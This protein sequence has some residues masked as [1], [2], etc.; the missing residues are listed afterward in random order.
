LADEDARLRQYTDLR[1]YD[2][3]YQAK[4]AAIKARRPDFDES[5]AENQAILQAVCRFEHYLE[6]HDS[7]M[8]KLDIQAQGH[9]KSAEMALLAFSQLNHQVFL[10]LARA[11]P[12]ADTDDLNKLLLPEHLNILRRMK[13]II[14]NTSNRSN[15]YREMAKE[16][17]QAKLS[18]LTPFIIEQAKLALSGSDATPL[19]LALAYTPSQSCCCVT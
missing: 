19:R 16:M 14:K 17:L 6:W 3:V 4:L 10:G 15:I 7:Y 8:E 13:G 11:E 12:V 2:K 5:K 18:G 9:D 1:F